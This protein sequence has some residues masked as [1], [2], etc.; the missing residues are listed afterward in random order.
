MNSSTVGTNLIIS[1]GTNW[2]GYSLY[3]S[4]SLA[5]E[6]AWTKVAK[7][8]AKVGSMYVISNG[9]ST[10]SQYY[11]LVLPYSYDKSFRD[12]WGSGIVNGVPL[13][14]VWFIVAA[15]IVG[16]ATT[17]VLVRLSKCSTAKRTGAGST[18]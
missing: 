13:A 18:G 11:R 14:I 3:S 9:I 8:P 4:T 6:A 2:T 17:A 1:W 16:L 10:S 5:T 12:M 15:I 7:S